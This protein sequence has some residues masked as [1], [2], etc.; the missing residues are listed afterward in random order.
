MVAATE[1]LRPGIE[2]AGSG[3]S[4]PTECVGSGIDQGDLP[5]ECGEELP[6]DGTSS[7]EQSG[8]RDS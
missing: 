4:E 6:L 7:P 8:G 1:T 5:E 2:D 3:L